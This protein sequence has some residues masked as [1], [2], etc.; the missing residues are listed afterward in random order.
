MP[1]ITL[2]ASADV[3]CWTNEA[4]GAGLGDH[5]PVGYWSTATYRS[6]IRFSPPSWA[7]WTKITKATLNVYISDHNHVGVRSSTIL[8]RRQTETNLWT[9]AAGT[10]D[11]ENG[12]SG[13]NN[14]QN[15]D[16]SSTSTDSATFTSGTT[17]NAKKS[18][19][20]TAAVNYYFANRT[21]ALV[22]TFAGNSSSDYAELWSRERGSTYDATLVI[23]YEVESVPNAPTLVAPASGASVAE[24]NPV[25]SWT[26][27]DAQSNPQ[28]AAE[29]ALY[30]AAGTGLLY[31]WPVAGAAG[32]LTAPDA[33]VRGTTYQ[34]AVRT[35]DAT[36]WGPFSAK[37]TFSI[38]E[39]PVITIDSTRRMEFASG[40]PRLLVKWSVSH[41]VAQTHYAIES[42]A[43]NIIAPWTAG[44]ASEYLMSSVGLTD[45]VPVEVGVWVRASDGLENVQIVTFTP[46][47]ALTTHRKDLGSAPVNW[48]TPSITAT[49]PTGASLVI[50]YGSN[51]T[52]APDPAAWYSTLSSVGKR[53]FLYWRA[54]FIPS[55]TAGPTLD[56]IIIPANF[57]IALVDHW[58]NWGSPTFGPPWAM[59][60]GEYVY[61]T[62]SVTKYCDGAWTGLRSEPIKLRAGR[63]YILTCLM[64]AEGDSWQSA[65]LIST[66]GTGLVNS[67]GQ[68]IITET[69]NATRDWFTTDDLDVYRYRTP[70][71]VAPSDMEV[72]AYLQSG[73]QVGAQA[74][75]DAIKVEE[76]T[77]ATPWSP[78]AVGASIVDAGGVQVDGVRGAVFRVRGRS[79]GLRDVVEGGETGLTF[80]TDTELDSPSTGVLAI[81]GSPV[82]TGSP[83]PPIRRIYTTVGGNVWTRP[84]GLSY[85]EVEAQG[86]GGGGAGAPATGASV[87]S[88]GAGGGGGGYA[89]RIITADE[90]TAAGVGVG[91]TA[92]CDV[93]AG[94]AGGTTADGTPG[95]TSAFSYGTGTPVRGNGGGAGNGIVGAASSN[96]SGGGGGALG[97]GDDQTIKVAGGYGESGYTQTGLPAL[98][99]GGS[100]HLG[101]GG[102]GGRNGTG[103]PP[104]A[105]YGGGGGGAA[106]AQNQTASDGAAGAQ[107][108]VIVTEYYS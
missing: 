13:S 88:S 95:S 57:T 66:D 106:N 51:D 87:G 98:C 38:R 107:G 108:I 40:A 11:C 60:T 5:L 39:L 37:R 77:V 34:Y 102:R 80:G 86:S 26:H 30:D 35:S 55:A 7:A 93:A 42:P 36:G 72:Y 71:F 8:V 58:F 52:A 92:A 65:Q 89:R 41:P 76:S 23:E 81:N 1:S 83:Q 15:S 73:G 2:T 21:S 104:A 103:L 63:S 10:Q 33:L 20:M 9:K 64:R 56:R 84:A 50:E 94:G 18:I 22:F 6:A 47:F 70:V 85:I 96:N 3:A 90:L 16:L 91:D 44:T 32:S 78:G 12:F 100:A 75:F 101:G 59:D 82:R 79:G 31:T 14:T 28:T 46:R 43:G 29:V 67:Q 99:G 45:G 68:S 27:S 48:E 62:R 61:G 74:W 24:T 53:R 49:V 25:F 17:A 69:L 19:V 4:Y 54:W 97:D 105:G